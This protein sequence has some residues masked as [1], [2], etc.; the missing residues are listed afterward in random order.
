MGLLS[1][2]TGGNKDVEG[3]AKNLLNG[4]NNLAQHRENAGDNAN[5]ALSGFSWGPVMPDEENQFN[6]NG[7]FDSYFENIYRAEF[8]DYRL[9]KENA[10]GSKRVIFT[11]YDETRKALVVELMP[12]SSMSKKLRETCHASGIPYLRFYYDHEGWWNTRSYVITRTRNA[13]NGK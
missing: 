7:T 1:K 9:E 10:T 13:L 8:P 5:N 4:L 11:F 6:Y 3:T 2:L 12:Q